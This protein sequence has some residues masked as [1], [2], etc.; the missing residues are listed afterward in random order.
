MAAEQMIDFL[1]NGTV[2]NSVNFPTTVLD[3]RKHNVGARVCVVHVNQP[4]A[5][6]GITTAI[7]EYGLNVAQQVNTSRGD[8]AYTVLDLED[9]PEN[10]A[11]V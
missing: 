1:E 2:R 5:L 11:E 7:S 9:L 8:I 6:A 3:A 4:G 10:T